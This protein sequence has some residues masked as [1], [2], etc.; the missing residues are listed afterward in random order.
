V[1]P[2][3]QGNDEAIEKILRKYGSLKYKKIVYFTHDQA[4]ALLKDAHPHIA[5]MSSHMAL[6]FPSGAL[7]KPAR[8]YLMNFPNLE[9]AVKCK[10]AIRHI[11]NM[12]YT[13]IHINDYHHETLKLAQFF[14]NAGSKK[15]VLTHEESCVRDAQLSLS[16]CYYACLRMLAR[17]S[18]AF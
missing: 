5:D 3:A 11:F 2:L 13:S 15:Y 6:Y 8:I 17:R 16:N 18:A 1:W 7:A 4:Y 9:T 10:H 12:G 14:F